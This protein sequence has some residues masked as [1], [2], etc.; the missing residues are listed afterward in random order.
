MIAFRHAPKT[1]PLYHYSHFYRLCC[2]IIGIDATLIGANEKRD[3]IKRG[4]DS[5]ATLLLRFDSL[6]TENGANLLVINH[7]H[8]EEICKK[9]KSKTIENLQNLITTKINFIDITDLMIAKHGYSPLDSCKLLYWE[10]DGHFKNI[11]YQKLAEAIFEEVNNKQPS[12]WLDLTLNQPA[13]E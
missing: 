3:E 8:P 9:I 11:G 1:E 6:A 7:M 10:D 12:L 2:R 13:K 5:M 4:I